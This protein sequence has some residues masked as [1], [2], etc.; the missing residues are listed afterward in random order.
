MSNPIGVGGKAALTI[1]HMAG[2]IDMVALPLWIGGLMQHYR[3]SPQHAGITVTLFLLGVVIASAVLAPLFNRIPRRLV[4]VAGFT[5]AAVCF[6]LMALQPIDGASFGMLAPLH[7]M[8]GLGAGCGL[9]LVHG[10][11]GRTDNPHRLFGM[12]NLAVA[13]LGIAVFAAVPGMVVLH[14]ASVLFLVFA[15]A[16]GLGALACLVGFPDVGDAEQPLS[17]DAGQGRRSGLIWMPIAVVICLTLNQSMVFAFVERIGAARGFGAGD[18]Q[19]VLVTLGFVNLLPGPL[20]AWM[21]HRVSPLAV[22]LAGPVGQALLAITLS[23]ALAFPPYALAVVLYV[24]MVIFTHT[25]LFGLLSRLDPSGRATSATPAMMMMGS[26]LGPAVGGFI[27]SGF[28]Y[29]GLGWAAG[30][31]SSVAVVL[32]LRLRAQ[33]RGHADADQAAFA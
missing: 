14:G 27:V 16:M 23:S 18:V 24:S 13:V 1:G 30:A 31:V 21:Q 26:C 12:V 25:F 20:A 29:Q 19:A 2:M 22:G 4:T 17:A 7:A 6:L 5:V 10:A 9:S 15:A 32:M 11:I 33:L 8:A 3:F 28:G